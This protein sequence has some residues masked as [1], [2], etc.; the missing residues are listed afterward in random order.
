MALADYSSPEKD[1]KL[2]KQAKEL[3]RLRAELEKATNGRDNYQAMFDRAIE[4][5]TELRA[6][7]DAYKRRLNWA[8]NELLACDYGDNPEGLQVGWTVFGSSTRKIYGASINAAIDAA[9]ENKS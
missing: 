4:R 5:E 2:R 8:A 6:E 9:L 3:Q 7:L 1:Q